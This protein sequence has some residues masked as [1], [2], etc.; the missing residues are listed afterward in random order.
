MPNRPYGAWPSPITADLI[1][2]S[3]IALSQPTLA[4][5]V[6]YWLEGRPTEGGRNVIMRRERNGIVRELNPAPLNARTRVNEYGGADYLVDGDTVYFSNFS[7]QRIYRVRPGET[8]APLTNTELYRYAD[9][10]IDRARNRLIC[11]RENHNVGGEPINTIAAIDLATGKET[12][13]VHGA[14]FYAYPRVSPDG[15]RLT[16]LEWDHPNMPWD[17]TTLF[18]A[19]INADGHL[20]HR[21]HIAGGREEAIFQPTWAPDGRL[22]FISD[23]SG[24]WNLYSWTTPAGGRSPSVHGSTAAVH[25]SPHDFGQPLWQLGTQTFA[26]D[27]PDRVIATYSDQGFWRL[28]SIDTR[29]GTMTP[30]ETPFTVV[31][32]LRVQDGKAVFVAGSPDAPSGLFSLDLASGKLETVKRASTLEIDEGYIS[33]PEAIEFPTAAAIGTPPEL[34]GGLTAFGFYYPPRNAENEGSDGTKT[35]AP[36]IVMSHGGPTAQT[37]ATLS[38]RILYWTSRGFGVLDV[39]YGGST[40][41]GRAYRRRLKG[42][43]GIVDVADCVNGARYLVQRGDADP[44]RLAITGGSAGGFTTLA[45]LAFDDTFKAGASHYGVADLEA[46]ADDTHKFESRYLDTL[47]GPYPA[48]KSRYIERSPVHNVATLRCP[49]IFFQGTED[50]IVPPNQTEM[51]VKALREKGIPVAYL[52]FEGEQHGFRR[53]ENIKRSLEAELLFYGRIFGFEPADPIEP[54]QI[55]NLE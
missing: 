29:A 7:D 21:R 38:P 44:E 16:W 19:L 41:Y 10:V 49:V 32:D 26:F 20:S 28:A 36:L 22:Y 47:V 2:S 51:M 53:A 42:T 25:P 45:A 54:V 17:G 8:P 46:L 1:V 4:D 31:R 43:W 34:G 23:I 24:W 9:G 6:L 37:A 13:L 52:S 15:T 30:I 5:G 3:S 35:P 50:R 18:V 14:S 48:E 11:V 40:G 39:N 33:R 55:E 27:G 12:T